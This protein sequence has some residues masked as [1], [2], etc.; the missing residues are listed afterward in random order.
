M[1]RSGG[2]HDRA[3]TELE[4]VKVL[5]SYLSDAYKHRSKIFR[6]KSRS[7]VRKHEAVAAAA[8]FSNLDVISTSAV[9]Q[10]DC[11]QAA[12][13]DLWK[14]VINYRLTKTIPGS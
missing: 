5:D 12:S 2:A 1:Y 10:N 9:N 11:N 14:E 7:L 4:E 6:P 8:F 13:A 3:E